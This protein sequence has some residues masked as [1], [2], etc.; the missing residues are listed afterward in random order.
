LH[1]TQIEIITA[2]QKI[3]IWNKTTFYPIDV[4][5]L[6]RELIVELLYNID[7][8]HRVHDPLIR[9]TRRFLQYSN[10][11]ILAEGMA[12]YFDSHV[13]P[14][15]TTLRSHFGFPGYPAGGIAVAR[16]YIHPFQ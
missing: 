16:M 3:L 1:Y 4:P 11:T 8:H 6:Y 10:F 7:L 14:Y 5:T 15:R 2:A 9:R 13:T 12:G